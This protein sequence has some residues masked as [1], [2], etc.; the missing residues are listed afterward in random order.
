[1]GGRPTE[2]RNDAGVWA[3]TCFVTRAG[4]RHR[5]IARAL[6]QAAV[7]FARDRGARALEAY[8]IVAEPDK[9]YDW[10]E[11]HVG[12]RAWLLAA[13]FAEVSHPT[14]RR[15]VMRIDFPAS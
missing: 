4:Y 9:R 13:G 1:M 10:G 11:L 5:G 15:A 6:T 8:P 14:P 7:D 2:D 3:L 12:V